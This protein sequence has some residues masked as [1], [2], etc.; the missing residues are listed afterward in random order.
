MFKLRTIWGSRLY[1][2]RKECGF[3]L[4]QTADMARTSKSYV[5]EIENKQIKPSVFTA[6]KLAKALGTTVEALFDPDYKVRPSKQG[7]QGYE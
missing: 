7:E 6:M 5:W 2:R 3:T 1:K 4:Q